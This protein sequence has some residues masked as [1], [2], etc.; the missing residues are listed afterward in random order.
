MAGS[1]LIPWDCETDGHDWE[2]A[3][4]T[5]PKT[6]KLCG[7]AEGEALG[8]DYQAIEGTAAAATCIMPGKEAD[9]KCSRCDDVADGAVISALGHDWGSWEV[10]IPAGETTE[11]EETRTCA[12]CYEEEVR[13][14]PT[15]EHIHLRSFV[16]AVDPTCTEPGHIEYWICDQGENPC[17]L[18]FSADD[19]SAVISESDTILYPIGHIAGER[20]RENETEADCTTD[21]TF[22]EVV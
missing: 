10:T 7:T 4:C 20:V 18:Y 9:K 17:G 1:A 14:I 8:H 11:G 6:C 2:P 22:D 16:D 3:T 15:M 13:A 21:S 19:D 12:R 5:V